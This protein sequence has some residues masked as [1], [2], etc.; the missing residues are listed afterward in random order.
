MPYLARRPAPVDARE[1]YKYMY[2]NR[3]R[4]DARTNGF[5]S[6]TL[7]CQHINVPIEEDHVNLTNGT[8]C[9]VFERRLEFC[10]GGG[11]FFLSR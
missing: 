8:S 9:S 5:Q 2:I 11:G 4:E 7:P 6:S 10:G 1:I 3:R